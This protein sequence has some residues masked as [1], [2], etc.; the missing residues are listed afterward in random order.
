L[1]VRQF[2]FSTFFQSLG[3][4]SSDRLNVGSQESMDSSMAHRQVHFT[5]IIHFGM[6]QIEL[7]L[8]DLTRKNLV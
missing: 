6:S 5:L 4:T 2:Q 3:L 1:I 7:W 8:D